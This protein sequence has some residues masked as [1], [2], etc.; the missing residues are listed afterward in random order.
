[1]SFPHFLRTICRRRVLF[2]YM[3]ALSA[4]LGIFF[5]RSAHQR[6]AARRNY[7]LSSL[8]RTVTL[9]ELCAKDFLS[10]KHTYIYKVLLLALVATTLSIVNFLL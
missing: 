1:M 5:I 10:W 7:F 4:G 9:I 8:R 2:E 6:D 3:R